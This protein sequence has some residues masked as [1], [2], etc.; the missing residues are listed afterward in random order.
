MWLTV[1]SKTLPLYIIGTRIYPNTHNLLN[2]DFRIIRAITNKGVS[3]LNVSA[4]VSDCALYTV[5]GI[6]VNV[7]STIPSTNITSNY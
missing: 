6:Q 3:N 7:Y 1:H 2:Y 5:T 4:S